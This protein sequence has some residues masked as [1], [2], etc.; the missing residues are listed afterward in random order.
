MLAVVGPALYVGVVLPDIVDVR[1][2]V[3]R[4][5]VLGV[6]VVTYISVFAGV[7]AVLEM[8]GGEVPAVG[9]LAVVGVLVAR[10]GSA[11]CR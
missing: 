6:A 2:L 9:V 3:V 5:V 8:V 7:A 10:W 4:V 11:R 1:G